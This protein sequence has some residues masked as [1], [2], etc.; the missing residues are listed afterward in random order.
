MA[1]SE[2]GN[3]R[4]LSLGLGT[5]WNLRDFLVFEPTHVE[6]NILWQS[7]QIQDCLMTMLPM[8]RAAFSRWP[9]LAL[10]KAGTTYLAKAWLWLKA[11]GRPGAALRVR[12]FTTKATPAI[13]AATKA[14]TPMTIPAIAPPLRP[15]EV[16]S[17]SALFSCWV[18]PVA[19]GLVVEF[20]EAGTVNESRVQPATAANSGWQPLPN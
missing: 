19:C 16:L 11:V 13:I 15:L 20:N 1:W 18:S 3:A 6:N 5:R 4:L 2:M 7:M 10:D 12:R 8:T 9:R 17:G 14:R